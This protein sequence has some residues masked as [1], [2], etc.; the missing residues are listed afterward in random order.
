MLLSRYAIY[1]SKKVQIHQI[2]RRLP[3]LELRLDLYIVHLGYPPKTKNKTRITKNSKQ[4]KSHGMFRRM[5]KT[6]SGFSMIWH[7]EISK[8]HQEEQR[9]TKYYLTRHAKLQESKVYR[10]KRRLAS[11]VSI[12]FGMKAGGTSTHTETRTSE[13]QELAIEL[14]SHIATKYKRRKRGEY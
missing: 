14:H 6:M 12:Y 8:I 1:G 5:N 7:M 10:H 13:N 3:L 2:A 11:M 4:Q 9:L